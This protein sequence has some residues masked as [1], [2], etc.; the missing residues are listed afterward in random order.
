MRQ[1]QLVNQNWSALKRLSKDDDASNGLGALTFPGQHACSLSGQGFQRMQMPFEERLQHQEILR[2]VA[3]SR[4]FEFQ[5]L[6]TNGVAIAMPT[7]PF[8]SLA[9]LAASGQC[10]W[11]AKLDA[12]ATCK[13]PKKELCTATVHALL[14]VKCG[15]R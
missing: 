6:N 12:V 1:S 5:C 7:W 14:T 10:V 3:D 4:N 13:I 8:A 11:H 9:Y 15:L 2:Q